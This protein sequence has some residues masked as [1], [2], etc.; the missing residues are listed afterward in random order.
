MKWVLFQSLT[1]L[2]RLVLRRLVF[3]TEIDMMQFFNIFTRIWWLFFIYELKFKDVTYLKGS[4]HAY[5]F[6]FEKY[7]KIKNVNI[8]WQVGQNWKKNCW[9]AP[10]QNDYLYYLTMRAV[11]GEKF[12]TSGTWTW[13]FHFHSLF[14]F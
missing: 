1:T 10:R 4:F 11:I 6:S 2:R 13:N 12:N 9:D 8:V 3:G 14:L 7:F 5:S